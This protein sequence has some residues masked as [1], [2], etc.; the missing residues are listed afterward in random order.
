MMLQVKYSGSY[1]IKSAVLSVLDSIMT[2]TGFGISQWL[3]WKR[4][5]MLAINSFSLSKKKVLTCV[6][7]VK[8]GTATI[9]GPLKYSM[10]TFLAYNIFM[11]GS[12]RVPHPQ[13]RVT[14]WKIAQAIWEV[15]G[16]FV[17]VT[18]VDDVIPLGSALS[19]FQKG[20]NADKLPNT[21]V[22][23]ESVISLLTLPMMGSLY[24]GPG[25]TPSA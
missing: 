6:K 5:A 22:M 3:R 14:W 23:S 9:W 25:E 16:I 13:Y 1:L 19:A 11:F 4:Y 12:L 17:S 15:C 20:W 21:I 24:A 18:T 2:I 10:C 7:I 8:R